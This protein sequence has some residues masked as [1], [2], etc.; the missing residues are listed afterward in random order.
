MRTVYS[1]VK[2]KCNIFVDRSE[3][4][5]RGNDGNRYFLGP[6]GPPRNARKPITISAGR[7]SEIVNRRP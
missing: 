6:G 7:Q 4:A 5:L 2:T 3:I 1:T